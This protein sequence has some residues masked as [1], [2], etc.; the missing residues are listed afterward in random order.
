[1]Y[2]EQKIRKSEALQLLF[3]YRPDVQRERIAVKLEFEG[4]KAGNQ[5]DF[6]KFVLRDLT[7]VTGVIT[8]GELVLPY[9]SSIILVETP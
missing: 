2:N 1:M 7:S 6:E 8:S 5:P 4:L 9:T 3:I